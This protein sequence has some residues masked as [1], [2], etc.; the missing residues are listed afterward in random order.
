[1]LQL[2]MNIHE[3]GWIKTPPGET[4]RLEFSEERARGKEIGSKEIMLRYGL[5]AQPD[6]LDGGS[7]LSTN[8]IK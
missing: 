8:R 4:A 2:L 1:M 7:P 5:D 3:T 6:A